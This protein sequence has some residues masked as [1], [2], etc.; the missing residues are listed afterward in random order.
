M[1]RHIGLLLCS[2]YQKFSKPLPYRLR[3]WYIEQ[4]H[5]K[6]AFSYH[7]KSYQGKITYFYASSN[8]NS[9]DYKPINGWDGIAAEGISVIEIPATHENIVEHPQLGKKLSECL[10]DAQEK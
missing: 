3:Y 10:K 9:D 8:K 6:A 4:K 5:L 1:S 2:A 7:T